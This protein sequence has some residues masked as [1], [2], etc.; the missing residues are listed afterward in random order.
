MV[1]TA[2]IA[3]A[4]TSVAMGA[5]VSRHKTIIPTSSAGSATA[6]CKR[7]MKPVA[8]GFAAPGFNPTLNNGPVFRF[9]SMP[10]GKRGI[11][12][13]AFNFSDNPGELDSYAYCAK[14]AHVLR[15]KSKRVRLF[16]GSYG[17]VVAR[18]PH[19]RQAVG[20]GFRTTSFTMTQGAPIFTFT[21]KRSGKRGWKAAGLNLGSPGSGNPPGRLTAYAYCQKKKAGPKVLVRSRT[22]RAPAL[23]IRNV[24]VKC[25]HRRKALSG[26]FDGHYGISS[27]GLRVAAA[28][29]SKRGARARAWHTAALGLS[30]PDPARITAYVYCGR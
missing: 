24:D 13:A 9:A 17:S 28:I 25:P 6:Q 19:G 29:T 16:P 3:I 2:V 11:K 30:N 5:V 10:A 22:V 4:A 1:A 21:S 7:G 20:G 12:T 23:N 15:I 27:G 14:R 18:C 26:G 8:G